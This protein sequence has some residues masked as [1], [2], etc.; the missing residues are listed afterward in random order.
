MPDDTTNLLRAALAMMLALCIGANLRLRAGPWR[1]FNSLNIL[2]ACYCYYCLIGPL[3]LSILGA[4]VFDNQ[5]LL[6][7]ADDATLSTI[8]SLATLFCGYVIGAWGSLS[9]KLTAGIHFHS[10]PQHL[11][12][13]S[14]FA[15]VLLGLALFFGLWGHGF[16]IQKFLNPFGA[17]LTYAGTLGESTGSVY[18]SSLYNYLFGSIS[19]MI[20]SCAVI[21][22]AW[23]LGRANIWVVV[24]A[25]TLTCVVFLTSGFRLRLVVLIISLLSVH[26]LVTGRRPSLL[27]LT[28]VAI[29]SFVLMGLIGLTRVYGEGIDA[30]AVSKVAWDRLLISMFGDSSTFYTMGYV[31]HYVREEGIMTWLD[32]LWGALARPIPLTVFG[33]K[34]YSMTN[35]IIADSFGTSGAYGSGFAIPFFGEYFIALRWWGVGL[36]SFGVGWLFGAG[37]RK[38]LTKSGDLMGVVAYSVWVA[39]SFIFF[40][41]GY[42]AQTLEYLVFVMAPS[43]LALW[44]GK[45]ALPDVAKPAERQTSNREIRRGHRR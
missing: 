18:G 1:Y 4:G 40:H 2:L 38:L 27:I 42:L 33:A 39:F 24:G 10:K 19:F 21:V 37:D 3:A 14:I 25:S 8:L 23:R 44:L 20:T 12:W 22:G 43:I 6:V 34:Y 11:N 35:S 41:R 36:G 7:Y 17:D 29:G 30:S 45:Q 31:M 16:R 5:D 32:P 26:S 28:A 9:P 15:L 13:H